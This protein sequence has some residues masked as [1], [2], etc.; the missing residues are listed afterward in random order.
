MYFIIYQTD[1]A[2]DNV[3]GYSIHWTPSAAIRTEFYALGEG[4]LE[5]FLP[6]RMVTV[7]LI[8]GFL[9]LLIL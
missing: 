5:S 6:Q 1:D 4:F 3:A 2:V 7:F 9:F 8:I